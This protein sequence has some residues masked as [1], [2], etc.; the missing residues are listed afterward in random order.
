MALQNYTLGRGELYFAPFAPGTTNP[1]GERYFGNTPEFNISVESETLDHFSADTPIREKDRS[2]ALQVN[3]SASLM[4]DDIDPDNVALFFLGSDSVVTQTQTT[5]TA[6][7]VGITNIGVEK[8]MF[9]QLGTS[10]ARPT[11][12]RSIIFPGT[13]GTTFALKKGATVLVH[14][15]D[16]HLNAE[17]GRIEILEGSTTVLNG[18]TL[19][20]DYTIGASSR[21]RVISGATPI[22]GQLR[23]IAQNG[24]GL[25]IDYLMPSVMVRPNGEFNL[26]GDDWQMLGFTVEILKKSGF[27]AVYADGRPYIA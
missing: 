14:G 26:K 2:A 22:R 7:Q 27:E 15:T 5:I 23:Y 20:A 25:N 16:Y 21:S 18:D 11:G 10:A 3:R 9:Y 8:G 19:T 1:L 13:A 17:L 6:E 24:E 12:A 4:T